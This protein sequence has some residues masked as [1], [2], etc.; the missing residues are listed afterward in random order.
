M[1]K[2]ELQIIYEYNKENTIDKLIQLIY[3]YIENFEILIPY[4]KDIKKYTQKTIYDDVDLYPLC[5]GKKCTHKPLYR[6]FPFTLGTYILLRKYK[7]IFSQLFTFLYFYVKYMKYNNINLDNFDYKVTED[8]YTYI[9][10]YVII[11]RASIMINP[12]DYRYANTVYGHTQTG[13]STMPHF[14]ISFTD[15]LETAKLYDQRN[16]DILTRIDIKNERSAYPVLIIYI[17]DDD[18]IEAY[19]NKKNEEYIFPPYIA[20]TN[21]HFKR[22]IY[23]EDGSFLKFDIFKYQFKQYLGGYTKI[24]KI[25]KKV[26]LGKE[27]CIYKKTGDRKEYL[28]YKGELITVKDYKK[29]KAKPCV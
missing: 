5:D 28:K 21:L 2:E 10:K 11:E 18:D 12:K 14:F 24:K 17:N 3:K 27:R 25:N 13:I 29:I 9:S 7:G 1:D 6:A 15:N 23:N 4:L 19:Y 8:M 20:N 22:G 26:I 16:I